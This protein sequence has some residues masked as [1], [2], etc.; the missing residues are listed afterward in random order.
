M[1]DLKNNSEQTNRDDGRP[2][3]SE[4][5]PFDR[6]VSRRLEE[7]EVTPPMDL[8]DKIF[9]V[10]EEQE[11]KE[12]GAPAAPVK[13]VRSFRWRIPSVAAIAGILIVLAIGV[14]ELIHQDTVVVEPGGQPAVQ[15]PLTAGSPASKDT[16]IAQKGAN[17]AKVD[18]MDDETEAETKKVVSTATLSTRHNANASP[19]K[20]SG[21][22]PAAGVRPAAKVQKTALAAV[23]ANDRPVQADSKQ[24]GG[25]NNNVAVTGIAVKRSSPDQALA[26]QIKRQRK[27]E[28]ASVVGQQKDIKKT[29]MPAAAA[30]NKNEAAKTAVLGDMSPRN[31]NNYALAATG[32]V[33][34]HDRAVR[35]ERRGLLKGIFKKI[36][37]TAR[38]ITDDVVSQD[39][40]KTVINVGVL[41]ITAYK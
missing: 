23:S 32:E 4:S 38:A 25:D 7:A 22:R 37:N 2:N 9:G 28:T 3:E 35:S 39:E 33:N 8:M 24:G 31:D 27:I 40:D 26:T 19:D 13:P 5:H 21:S 6:Q 18:M 12:Q 14:R 34:K 29:T 15:S 1:Q 10:L 36:G 16:K 11:P 20:R 41:A 30:G 17:T